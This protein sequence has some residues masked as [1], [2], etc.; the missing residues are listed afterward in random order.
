MIGQTLGHYEIRE[1]I[2]AGG[3]GEVYRARDTKLGRDVALKLLP[4]EIAQDPQRRE[5]FEREA[6]AVAALSHPNIM[7]IHEFGAD[8]GQLFAIAELLEGETLAECLFQGPVP[9]RKAIECAAQIADGLAAAH[10]QGIIHRDLKP[11]N[12]FITND[13]RVKILDFGL[14]KLEQRGAGPGQSATLPVETDPGTVLGTVGYMSPEQVRGET[15]D[16]RSDI[17]SLGVVLY[18]MLAGARAFPGDSPADTMGAILRDEPGPLHEKDPSFPESLDRIIQHCLEKNPEQRFQSARDL[19]FALRNATPS[20]QS[21]LVPHKIASRTRCRATLVTATAAGWVIALASLAWFHFRSPEPHVPPRMITL[22]Y[23]GRDWSPT[24]SPSGEMVAFVSDRDGVPRIW[25]KQLAGGGEEPLTDGLDD[26]PRFSPDGSQILFVRKQDAGGYALF[27]TSVVGGQPRKI[28]DD[29]FGGDWSPSGDQVAFLRARPVDEGNVLVIGVAD[30]Q[31]GEERVVSTEL[32]NRLCY[33]IRWSPD[34][35]R[36]AIGETALTG[37][38]PSD[39]YVDLIDVNT[40]HLERLSFTDWSGPYTAMLWGRDGRSL[41]IGQAPD[42]LARVSGAPSQIMECELESG[43]LRELLWAQMS[44]PMGGWSSSTIC[45]LGPGRLVIDEYVVEARLSEITYAAAGDAAQMRTLTGGL[46]RDRQPAY[47][48]DGE[49]IVFSSNRSGNIDLWIL[50]RRT[51]T[52]RQLTD[53]PAS[54][55]DPGFTPDGE[56]VLWSSD[57]S[58]NMEVWIAAPDGSGARQ[59]SHDGVDAENPTMTPDGEWII[60]GTTNSE[61]PGIWKIRADGSEA[62]PLA[63]GAYVIPEV[64]PE[65]R[66][67]SYACVRGTDYAIRVVEV[68]T[69]EIV[70][71]AIHISTRDLQENISTGRSRWT[72]DGKALVFVSQDDSCRTGLFIQDFVPGIDTSASRRPVAGF[73]SDFSTESHGLSPD[74]NTIVLSAVSDRRSIK[75]VDHV[76]LHDGRR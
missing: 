4:P 66:Y 67:A 48:P 65:G 49:L 41:I 40:G 64:S 74:G 26:L 62:T 29:A 1:R 16:A 51:G 56:H 71:F 27:R 19:G 73:S 43:S 21:E 36:I 5:R 17:F 54:D 59:L 53:D 55:W 30:V 7:T 57:H 32:E 63:E 18:E 28:L 31:T 47:S 39:S 22:T 15:V 2:G 68:Q 58:G 33:G 12:I 50:E 13:G 11:A 42:V 60:Y 45:S 72:P 6:R 24:T 52:L 14:A 44:A 46:A 25:L 75:L 70:P 8:Q 69:G 35:R 37:M 23:T 76:P 38:V 61:H 9:P 34:G 20:S 10:A 3:M